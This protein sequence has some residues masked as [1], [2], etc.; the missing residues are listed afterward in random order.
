LR[1]VCSASFWHSA[2][3]TRGWPSWLTVLFQLPFPYALFFCLSS[4]VA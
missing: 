2:R 3:L 1:R 4:N